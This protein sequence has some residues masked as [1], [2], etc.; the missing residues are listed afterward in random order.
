MDDEIPEDNRYRQQLISDDTIEAIIARVKADVETLVKK[1]G[2]MKGRVVFDD[3]IDEL[4]CDLYG[5]SFRREILKVRK[6]SFET[7]TCYQPLNDG[8]AMLI[9]PYGYD[10]IE[11]SVVP[12][13]PTIIVMSEV[14]KKMHDERMEDRG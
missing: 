4:C 8:K 6:K 3:I 13:K 9:S 1:A 11:E 2:Q 14:T 7:S 10:V 12:G 5:F